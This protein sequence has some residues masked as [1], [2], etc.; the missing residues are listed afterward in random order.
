MGRWRPNMGTSGIVLGTCSADRIPHR[1]FP[2]WGRVGKVTTDLQIQAGTTRQKCNTRCGRITGHPGD[3]VQETDPGAK[4]GS[5][6]ICKAEGQGGRQ[7]PVGEPSHLDLAL[8]VPMRVFCLLICCA[9]ETQ[10][11][12]AVQFALWPVWLYNVIYCLLVSSIVSPRTQGLYR[13]GTIFFYV[14]SVRIYNPWLAL[15][16]KSHTMQ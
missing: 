9:T 6:I 11:V 5:K 3:K 7:H 16:T 4:V 1:E 13:T 14:V 15:W 12:V 2:Q 10:A 8:W